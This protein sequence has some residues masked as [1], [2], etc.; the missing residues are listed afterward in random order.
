MAGTHNMKETNTKLWFKTSLKTWWIIF[1]ICL[2]EKACKDV[3]TESMWHL[4]ADDCAD[5]KK[6]FNPTISLNSYR[7]TICQISDTSIFKMWIMCENNF[8]DLLSAQ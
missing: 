4:K 3:R 5:S 7:Y 1:K 8:T 2:N 6:F